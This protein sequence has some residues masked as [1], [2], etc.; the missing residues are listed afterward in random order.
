[1]AKGDASAVSSNSSPRI[2]YTFPHD[3]KMRCNW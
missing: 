3:V 1:M 2:G